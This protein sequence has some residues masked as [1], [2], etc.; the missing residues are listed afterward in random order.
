MNEYTQRVELLQELFHCGMNLPLWTYHRSGMLISPS[1]YF[2]ESVSSLFAMEGSF[3]A[4]LNSGLEQDYPLLLTNSLN[5]M[6]IAAFE[7]HSGQ[8]EKIHVI[9]P[10]Y[11]DTMP[12]NQLEAVLPK[13]QLNANHRIEFMKK[14]QALPVIPISNFMQ[15][16]IMLHYCATGEKMGVHQF[17][18]MTLSD[19]ENSTGSLSEKEQIPVDRHGTYY[20]EATL[21]RMVEEGNLNYM[22]VLDP[23]ILTGKVGQL[24]VGDP[25]RHMKNML[26]SEVIIVSRAAIRGGLDPELSYSVSDEYIRR[27]ESCHSLAEL[28]NIPKLLLS[29]YIGRVHMLRSSQYGS[30]FVLDCVQYISAHIM[31]PMTI[32]SIAKDFGYTPYYLSR[33]FKKEHGTDLRIYIRDAR[34]EASKDLLRDK[35]L[36]VQEIGELLHFCSHSYFAKHFRE[37]YSVTPSEYRTMMAGT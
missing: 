33:K 24:S 37:K 23:M 15:C 19:R 8:L 4:A 18:Y 20:L 27:I 12:I 16:G 13:M 1:P 26:L 7:K 28:G 32:E 10:A 30:A 9:G 25:I 3:E 5:L 36:S 11:V 29:D 21:T 6:W 34:L 31:E 17:N 35:S 2:A 14:L 22:D